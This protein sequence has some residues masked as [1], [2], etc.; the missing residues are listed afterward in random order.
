M[1]HKAKQILIIVGAVLVALFPTSRR[2]ASAHLRNAPR[3]YFSAVTVEIKETSRASVLQELG[4]VAK[5]HRNAVEIKQQKDTALWE[6]GVYDSDPNRAAEKANTIAVTCRDRRIEELRNKTDQTLAEMKDE[7]RTKRE[8]MGQL[9]QE[10]SRI[11]QEDNIVDPDPESANAILSITA[12]SISVETLA[13]EKRALVDQ[14]RNQLARIEQL[15]PEELKEALR[16]LNIS[17]QTVEK[18]LPL[19]LDAKAR[20]TKLLSE[21]FGENHARMKSLRAERDVY[22]KI[23]SDQI[24]SIKRS[25]KTKLSIEEA[26]LKTYEE[27]MKSPRKTEIDE[28]TRMNRYVEK[29]AAYLMTKQLLLSIEQRY[30]AA[31]FDNMI[32]QLPL[33]IWQ[34]AMPAPYPARPDVGATLRLANAIGGSLGGIG[35]LLI[36]IAVCIKSPDVHANT[37]ASMNPSSLIALNMPTFLASIGMCGGFFMPWITIGGEIG[38]TGSTLA[39]IGEDGQI[40]WL[41]LILAAVAAIM[42]MTKPVKVLNVIAGIAPFGLLAYFGNKMGKEL[43]ENLGIGAW[44]ILVCGLV[45]IFAPVKSAAKD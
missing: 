26:T 21:G 41:I 5:Q 7:L 10:A 40:S 30:T 18:T 28:K 14:L 23:L 36:L 8:E 2:I 19:L 31:R 45:L 37:N 13:G 43:F 11:R 3:E 38:I 16:M 12:L 6:I 15:K 42:H 44:L 33:K 20:E 34:R 39:K 1:T 4:A 22:A 9:F 24:E 29:K 27:Q 25:Q 35:V 17:D 32:S